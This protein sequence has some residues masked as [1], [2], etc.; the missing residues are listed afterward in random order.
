MVI[1]C[2]FVMSLPASCKLGE[3]CDSA[4]NCAC[5]NVEETKLD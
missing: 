3:G 5:G 4:R 1:F 2:L